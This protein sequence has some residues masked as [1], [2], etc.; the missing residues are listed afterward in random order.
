MD[1]RSG[2]FHLNV[3]TS[4]LASLD[5][6]CPRLFVNSINE[7]EKVVI[8]IYAM[9]TDKDIWGEDAFEFKYAF[10]R[11]LLPLETDPN[12]PLQYLTDLNVGYRPQKP[13]LK[14]LVCGA[15]L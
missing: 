8:P 4:A 6:I 2:V 11:N 7:G 5:L 13:F 1:L 3:P 9:N 12:S 14:T 10:N 15:T